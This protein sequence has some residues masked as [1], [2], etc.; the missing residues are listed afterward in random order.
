MRRASA[1]ASRST[2]PTAGTWSPVSRFTGHARSRHTSQTLRRG[3][4]PLLALYTLDGKAHRRRYG[5]DLGIKSTAAK[6]S[7][8][9]LKTLLFL[10]VLQVKKRADERTRTAYPCSLRVCGQ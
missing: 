10:R 8:F 3:L 6:F 7:I 9:L 5:R 1:S 4:R 2:G